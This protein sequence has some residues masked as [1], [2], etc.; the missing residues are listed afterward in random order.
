[1]PKICNALPTLPALMLALIFSFSQNAFAGENFVVPQVDLAIKTNGQYVRVN[2]YKVPPEHSIG[3]GTIAYE[4]PGIES[5]KVA[6][7]LYLDERSVLDIFGKK[8]SDP[9]L[10]NVGR[11]DDYHTMSDWGM[12]ILKVGNSLGAGGLGVYENVKMRM[13]GPAENLSV[14]VSDDTQDS[15]SFIVKHEGL[16][17]ESGTFNLETQYSMTG[18][19]RLLSIHAQS[20]GD[21]PALTAGLVKHPGT[22]RIYSDGR[23]DSSW[24]FIATYGVQTLVDD[25]LG[26]AV[27]YQPATVTEVLDDGV[28]LG[29]IFKKE[30]AI[31]YKVAAAWAGEPNGIV[32]IDEFRTYLKSELERLEKASPSHTN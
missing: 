21:S 16:K 22:D 25:Q 11:G 3:D 13:V 30:E 32:N 6:Y 15:A 2:E 9:V 7:R 17:S 8:T 18:N 14:K 20:N 24:A 26:L 31:H 27:F 12:D 19:S 29:V 1:M 23:P 10:Q 5:D 4:G 28:T